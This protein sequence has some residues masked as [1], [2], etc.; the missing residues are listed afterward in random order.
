MGFF[1]E[2]RSVLVLGSAPNAIQARY[3]TKHD[4]DRVVV[5]NN[6]W[7]I[8]K[9]WDDLIYPYDFPEENMPKNKKPSQRYITEAEFVSVQNSFGG[10]VY[11]GGTMA[12]T[13]A[14]WVL[15]HYRPEHI[16]FLGCDMHYP[17][18]SNTHFYG[19]GKAD[20]LRKDITLISLEAKAS[21]LYIYAL[22]QNCELTNFSSGPS[23]LVFPR[24]VK[25]DKRPPT[26]AVNEDKKLE[27]QSKELELNYFVPSGRYWEEKDRFDV[28]KIREIDCLW[29]AALMVKEQQSSHT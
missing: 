18:N 14:Y 11:A 19:N 17:K 8:L 24:Q 21:R 16:A 9:S 12:F 13:A 7:K 15:G 23:R 3:W 26:L 27:A 29:E 22:E 20:P 4:F 10:F 6:A 28:E 1:S 5:I 25:D 2:I